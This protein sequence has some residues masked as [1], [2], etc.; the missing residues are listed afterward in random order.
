MKKLLIPLLLIVV[1]FTSCSDGDIE[2]FNNNNRGQLK[3]EFYL[4][5]QSGEILSIST[6]PTGSVV[7]TIDYKTLTDL[8]QIKIDSVYS[9]NLDDIQE[10]NFIIANFWY[11]LLLALA[12]ILI[13]KELDN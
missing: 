7:N 2:N 12:V 6:T 9:S 11:W 4:K 8:P 1:L 13:I 10:S 3:G 5:T